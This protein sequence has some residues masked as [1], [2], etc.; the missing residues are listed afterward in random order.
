MVG[1]VVT[2]VGM[3]MIVIAFVAWRGRTRA[4]V[5]RGLM[6]RAMRGVGNNMVERVETSRWLRVCAGAR[7]GLFSAV[8]DFEANGWPTM[9]V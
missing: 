1:G 4:V 9:K 6:A 7:C 5:R 8:E 3:E 2:V